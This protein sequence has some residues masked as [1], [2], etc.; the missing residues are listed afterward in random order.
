MHNF[1]PEQRFFPYLT[2]TEIESMPD[3]ENTVIIRPLGAIEQHGLHLHL[4]VGV[5]ISA[6][7]TGKA[8]ASLDANIPAYALPTLYYGNSTEHWHFSG[9]IMLSASTLLAV[10][11]EIADTIYR[12][13]IRK[14]VLM[15]ARG[16]QSQV[17]ETAARGIHQNINFFRFFHG[18]FGQYSGQFL[19]S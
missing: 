13:E 11:V 14:L 9:T 2:W 8:L 10:I 17:M 15:N 12:G 3:K 19:S 16:G 1:I 6:T 4:I 5:A 18:L 7:V